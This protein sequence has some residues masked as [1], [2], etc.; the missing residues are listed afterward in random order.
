MTSPYKITRD[1]AR[2]TLPLDEYGDVMTLP[3]TSSNAGVHASAYSDTYLTPPE[4][5]SELPLAGSRKRIRCPAYVTIDNMRYHIGNLSSIGRY[6][7]IQ[8]LDNDYLKVKAGTYVSNVISPK[9]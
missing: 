4:W 6:A 1:K 2:I 7:V 9:T 3:K 5:E 8:C